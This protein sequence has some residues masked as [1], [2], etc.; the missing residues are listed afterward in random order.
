MKKYIFEG[1]FIM[2]KKLQKTLIGGLSI[3]GIT[4]ISYLTCKG[5]KINIEHEKEGKAILEGLKA[6]IED[7]RKN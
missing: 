4:T 5:I 7:Y 1:D 6:G 2:S 3:V